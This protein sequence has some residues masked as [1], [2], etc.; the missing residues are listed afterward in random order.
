MGRKAL[1][2]MAVLLFVAAYPGIA[3]Y[4]G[5]TTADSAG[6]SRQISKDDRILQ[7]LNRLTFG[8]RP[9]DAAEVKAMGLKK[10]IDRQ[11]HP[12]RIAE[13]PVLLEKLKPFDTLAM[14]SE[15]LIRNYPAPQIVRQMAAGQLPFPSDPD[16]RM[17]IQK[18]VARAE[19]RQGDGAPLAPNAP[20]PQALAELLTPPEIRSLRT[21]TPQ[22]RLAALAALPPDKQADVIGA[23]PQG[24]RQALFVAA[25]PELR[26]RIELSAGPA[27]VVERDLQESKIL[28][29]VYSNR[30]LD[31][32]LADFWFN[33]FNV[34]MDKGADRYLTTEYERDA[35]RP[36]VLGH[37]RDLLEATAKSPAMLF[38]LDNWQSVGPNAPQPRGP[39]AQHRGLNE[40]YG[41][42][43]LELH[44]LGVDG[45]YTQ[46]DVTEVARCFTGWSINQPQRGGRFQFAPRLHDNGEK[47]V[48]GVK[49]P[50]G[51]GQSDGEK[52]LDIVA[53]HPSTAH[54]IARKLA[55]RF[56]ADSPPAALV[57][58]MAQTFLKT[59]GDLRAV[60]ETM[61]ASRE[62]WSEGA[63]RSKMKSPLEMVVSSVRAGNGSVDFATALVNQVAQLGEPLYRKQEPTGYS[64]SSREWMNTAGLMARMNFAL[65]LAGNKVPGVTV[66][67]RE[68]AADTADTAWGSPEFQKR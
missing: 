23:L 51:G 5:K 58:R 33:H 42:E 20:T 57:E 64:N 4:A 16:R 56:V 26:R 43:L 36:H 32:V 12:E 65:Q 10:W 14:A 19:K 61:L 46:K 21:G 31:E 55:E 44:T 68:G 9:G 35:I 38:Y 24:I 15:E 50:A 28:R 1:W 66:E 67:K 63:F 22:Q 34:F 59:D 60:M 3:V 18:L 27:Q 37:F 2:G 62:F 47:T 17:M 6:F 40:N 8:P 54:F 52:V 7:A 13:N 30:Q 29:A 45:G 49:I 41:R 11:L 48:L 53:R 39:N 25:P